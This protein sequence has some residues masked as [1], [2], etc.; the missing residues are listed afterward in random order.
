LLELNLKNGLP[1][2]AALARLLSAPL[3]AA[4][5]R[6]L[7]QALIEPAQD[8][9]G[10]PSKRLRAELLRLGAELLSR[11]T[12]PDPMALDACATAVELLHAGSLIVDDIQD[13]SPVRRGRA[14]IHE[15]YGT[16]GALCAG[17]W[18]YFWPLRVIKGAGLPP[19]RELQAF[20]IYHDA[21]ERA[22]YGQA[23][24]LSVRA[25][26]LNQ[27]DVPAL[28]RAVLELKTGAIT[29]LAMSLG[30][31]VAGAEPHEVEA[32]VTFGKRFGVALQQLDDLGNV[33]G[34]VD[35][36]KRFEDLMHRK[37]SAVWLH[38]AEHSDADAYAGFQAAVAR[39]QD[40]D[41]AA[42]QAWLAANDLL[43]AAVAHV[44][45]DLHQAYTDL[46]AA[47]VLAPGER[48]LIK[49]R[50]L[51]EGLLNAYI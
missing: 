34:R 31:V 18:L 14:A 19:A 8:L 16:P 40:G 50:A 21:V 5:P 6:F 48:S 3:D 4:L 15:L 37:L 39:L 32:V 17:N 51:A 20:G 29:A 42:L 30:A 33:V 38:A 10:R 25:D 7:A 11:G 22:H 46:V 9:I 12:T 26:T 41:Q 13:G 36:E 43:G 47:L 27:S 2:D 35:P 45:A 1:D 24:D 23:L 28:A 49:L 44:R